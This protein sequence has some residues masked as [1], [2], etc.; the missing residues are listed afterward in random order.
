MEEHPDVKPESDDE[1]S[2]TEVVNQQD[3]GENMDYE[4]SQDSVWTTQS[5]SN[6]TFDSNKQ[7][8]EG[9]DSSG[10]DLSKL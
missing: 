2:E 4:D 3:L 10:N 1:T 7:D 8:P 5:T 6:T 9:A